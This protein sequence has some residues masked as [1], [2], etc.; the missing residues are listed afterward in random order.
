M[1][2]R[3]CVRACACVCFVISPAR[4]EKHQN[5]PHR[6]HLLQAQKIL[7]LPYMCI[8]YVT[9]TN[10]ISVKS[11]LGYFEMCVIM[12]NVTLADYFGILGLSINAFLDSTL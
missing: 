4:K 11:H 6:E 12:K 7:A 3:A 9:L 2:V 5:T 8:I 1:C 10:E